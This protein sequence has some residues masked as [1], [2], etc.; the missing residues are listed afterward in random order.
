MKVLENRINVKI[1]NAVE[2]IGEVFILNNYMFRLWR[3]K[4]ENWEELW[5]RSKNQESL[6]R[7]PY[8]HRNP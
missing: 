3:N 2:K 6:N 7:G 4:I 8:P 5:M 1:A